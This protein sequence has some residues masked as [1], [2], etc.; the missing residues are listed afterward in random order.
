MAE[1]EQKRNTIASLTD[2]LE[3]LP[4]LPAV[5]VRLMSVS[6]AA[7]HYFETVLALA[8][9]DPPFAARVIQSANAA[10]SAPASPIEG[11]NEAVTRLGAR[12]IGELV[13][14]MAITEV[15]VPHTDDQRQ[16]WI[17]ALEVAIV[18]REVAILFDDEALAPDRLYLAGLL[19]DIGRFIMFDES[20]DQ[21][22]AVDEAGWTTPD[23]LVEV[24]RGICG[25]D[26]AQLGA[27]AC[28]SWGIPS[29][30]VDLVRDHH[31]FDTKGFAADASDEL[32]TSA[33]IQLADRISVL[34]IG[35]RGDAV[36][37]SS[38]WWE[39]LAD[40][41]IA[42]AWNPPPAP[43]REI[44]EGLPDLLDTSERLAKSLGLVPT[45]E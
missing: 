42:S 5:I 8:E 34:N 13:T 28:D 37:S 18:A 21:L 22:G 33:I 43:L 4:V 12:R 38:S 11:L 24:E 26:H 1:A 19:H 32:R 10:D 39:R 29:Q 30:I 35:Q 44:A 25:F 15:F 27:A 2:R 7:D 45:E 6:P 17:H 14:A 36:A 16:L 41:G 20:P 3:T 40:G 31:R 9:T 23:E